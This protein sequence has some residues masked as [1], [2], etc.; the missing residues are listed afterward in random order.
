MTM[1]IK[2]DK[3]A[4]M[5]ERAH[6]QDAGYDL[7]T[8]LR[9][10]L[11]PHSSATIDT[12]VHVQIPEGYVGFLKAKSGLNV[13]HDITGTGVI[14]SGYTGSI[15]VKLYNNGDIPHVFEVGDKLIQLV[16]LPI[17]TPEL[18]LVNDLEET[19]RGSDGF[20]STGR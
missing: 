18:E 16:I 10:V 7:R 17:L 1:K 9:F 4:F 6:K 12:G 3:D 8:P 13:E 2:L 11:H 15:R 14:D 5:P 19:E 20:G